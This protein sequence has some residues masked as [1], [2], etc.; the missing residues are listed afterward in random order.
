MKSSAAGL[1]PEND[2]NQINVHNLYN[3]SLNWKKSWFLKLES[4]KSHSILFRIFFQW[5]LSTVP[6]FFPK[7]GSRC[8]SIFNQIVSISQ[9][10][11][12]FPKVLPKFHV[13]VISRVDFGLFLYLLVIILFYRMLYGVLSFLFLP[14]ICFFSKNCSYSKKYY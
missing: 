3:W 10:W 6:I 14:C 12:L 2:S 8:L 4:V 1:S 11:Y 13:V 9:F 5:S 7:K